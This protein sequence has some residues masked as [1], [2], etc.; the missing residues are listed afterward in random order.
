MTI[1]VFGL[2]LKALGAG[3]VTL[4]IE[5]RVLTGT[6]DI[7]DSVQTEST[8]FTILTIAPATGAPLADVRVFFDLNKA[9]TGFG[10]VETTATIAFYIR[11]KVDGTNFRAEPI[12]ATTTGTV[13]GTAP[14]K[15]WKLDI[16]DVGVDEDVDIQAVMS[17]DATTD[18]E[19][20]Y[21]VYYKGRSAPTVTAINAV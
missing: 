1:D 14:A 4:P 6:T 18:M 12:S 5:T 20:P 16:G 11:R 3:S 21:A 15:L 8:P 7:D 2:A 13:A 17:A 10:A 9:T 19:I